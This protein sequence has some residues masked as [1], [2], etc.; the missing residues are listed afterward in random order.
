VIFK[1][2]QGDRPDR[3]SP[4]FSDTLWDLLTKTWDTEDGPASQRR[5]STSFVRDRLQE[6]RN[7][8]GKSIVPLC[9]EFWQTGGGY[10]A[11]QTSAVD[12]SRTS[13]SDEL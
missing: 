1:V 3:P 10:P 5:P 4:G 11:R 2:V 12:Y 9:P 7:E 6:D 13:Y 8:W